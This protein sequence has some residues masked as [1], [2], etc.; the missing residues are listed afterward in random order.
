MDLTLMPRS[1]RTTVILAVALA[2]A[3][4]L[5][6]MMGS[7]RKTRPAPAPTPAAASLAGLPGG[8]SGAGQ[9]GGGDALP[10]DTGGQPGAGGA[11]PTNADTAFGENPFLSLVEEAPPGMPG[12]D[13]QLAAA[14]AAAGIK[15][16]PSL[17]LQGTVVTGGKAS[18][19]ISGRYYGVGQVVDG[20][21]VTWI[22]P[23]EVRLV[24]D[25]ETLTLRMERE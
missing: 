12:G 25:G 17:T 2:A 20:W 4:I 16:R 6:A 23:R 19:L 5:V 10:A 18:A 15:P 24:R 1:P 3:L 13:P 14:L 7:R 8:T 11:R 21:R 22:G 9:P